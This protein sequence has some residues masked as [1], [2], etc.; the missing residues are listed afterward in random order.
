MKSARAGLY[1][2]PLFIMLLSLTVLLGAAVLFWGL[3]DIPLLTYNEARRAVPAANMIADGDWLLPKL[4]GELYITKPPLIYWAAAATSYLFGVVNEWT[5][6]IPSALAA[7]AIAILAYRYALR[8]FGAWSALFT[9]QILIANAGFAMLGRRAGI[10]MLL[11]ALCFS[12]LLSALKYTHENSGRQWLLLSYFLLGAAVLAKGPIAL[13]FVTVPLL[14]DALYQRQP[15]QW[16]ALRDPLGWVIFLLVGLSWYVA[17]TLQMGVDIWRATVHTDM[18]NKM[19]GASGEPFYNYFLWLAAD[20]FPASLLLFITPVAVW[21]RWKKSD[22][23]VS[24]CIAFIVPFLIYT[25]F[26]DKHAKYLLPVYPL[27]AILLGCRLGEL[28][29]NAGPRLRRC[30]FIAG[31]LLPAGYAA[32]YAVAEARMFHYRYQALPLIKDW[33][34]GNVDNVPVYGYV[35][36]DE[37]LIYYANRNIPIIDDAKL[38]S[39]KTSNAI[40]LVEDSDI[41]KIQPQAKCLIKE[42]K[43]Y[44]KKDGTLAVFGFGS[45]CH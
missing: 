8:Q 21:L 36:L 26:S 39:L 9:L 19:Y 3:G 14:F 22:V 28:V 6:R 29:S 23:T 1:R 35:D 10:E 45:A 25:A 27:V 16:Q 32:F 11:A 37:R 5:V 40:L 15:R 33:F 2:Q 17:V 13:L 34:A 4:N 44:L 20:F 7:A 42:F 12:S 38:E 18:V 43:P 24:L 30:L 31:I 41:A